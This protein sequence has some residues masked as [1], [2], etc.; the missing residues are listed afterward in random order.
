M[1]RSH[2]ALALLVVPALAL[3]LIA[4]RTAPTDYNSTLTSPT[5]S[6][7]TIT[8]TMTAAIANFSGLVTGDAG[9]IASGACAAVT[10]NTAC[11]DNN[12]VVGGQRNTDA[13]PQGLLL[14]PQAAF[15][16][17][18]QT[19][20]MLTLA[21]GQDET[22]IAIDGADPSVS[23]AGDNDSVT[24]AVI[25]SNGA[26][27][28]TV[29]TEGTNWTASASVANTCASLA[30]AVDALAGV[31]AT[32]TSPNVRFTL[33]PSTAQVTLTESTAG[34]TTVGTGTSGVINAFTPFLATATASATTPGIAFRGD[35]NTGIDN[36]SADVLTLGT[37]GTTRLTVSTSSIAS[38]LAVTTSGANGF[39]TT[40]GGTADNSLAPGAGGVFI[41]SAAD[42]NFWSA[43]TFASGSADTNL[44]R[45]SAGAVGFGTG[46]AGSTAGSL[47]GANYYVGSSG[48]TNEILL[49]SGFILGASDNIH[50]WS[51]SATNANAGTD[52]ALSRVSAGVVGVGTGAVGSIAGFLSARGYILVQEDIGAT[53]TTG[54]MGYDTGGSID[55]LCYCQATNTWMCTA[56]TAGPAD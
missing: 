32:C 7:P 9:F 23:C 55:E 12:G 1:K 8:G 54:S 50:G 45:I 40:T 28:S 44:S 53:C 30:S 14:R 34:C 33:D 48:T 4:A 47:F 15:A 25:D 3:A 26:T 5:L 43:T 35:A 21:G 39:Q 29:L 41:N 56:V 13:A 51:S 46:V 49:T 2:K 10:G 31:G 38:T 20:S 6:D 42:L 18:T 37:G 19:A 16:G 36:P 52:T 24:V 17:G 11:F 22:T 27:T